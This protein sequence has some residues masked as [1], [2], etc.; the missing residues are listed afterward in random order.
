MLKHIAI[1]NC[2]DEGSEP[3]KT[4]ASAALSAENDERVCL[5]CLVADDG[6]TD[7]SCSFA[8]HAPGVVL[9]RGESPAGLGLMRNTACLEALRMGADTISF[10]DAHMRFPEGT[11]GACAQRAAS[12]RRVVQAGSRG[13]VWQDHGVMR[14]ARLLYPPAEKAY[15]VQPKWHPGPFEE[16]WVDVPALMGAGYFMSADTAR[17]LASPGQGPDG[18]LW[19]DVYA[20][21]GGSEELLSIKAF[22]MGVPIEV[23]RDHWIRHEYMGSGHPAGAY[24]DHEVVRNMLGGLVALWG[25]EV[26]MD[27]MFQSFKRHLGYK[28]VQY[29]AGLAQEKVPMD[30]SVYVRTVD[31]VF[32]DLFENGETT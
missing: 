15:T 1:F 21:W 24:S 19:E 17:Y 9:T 12:E 16:E 5:T 14:G 6:S 4:V 27:R 23:S 26:V 11:I 10:H 31:D 8:A 22:M 18:H 7:R 28:R 30:R 20:R 3:F 13:M 29:I 32:N 2:K 25:R